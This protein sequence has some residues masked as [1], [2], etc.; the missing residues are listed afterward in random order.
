MSVDYSSAGAGRIS[1]PLTNIVL[2]FSQIAKLEDPLLAM[3]PAIAVPASRVQIMVE[4]DSDLDIQDLERPDSAPIQGGRVGKDER[5]F[6]LRRYS[7]QHEVDVRTIREARFGYDPGVKAAM[8]SKMHVFRSEMYKERVRRVSDL[9]PVGSGGAT[10]K[11]V[12]DATGDPW[13]NPAATSQGSKTWVEEGIRTLQD[14]TGEGREAFDV[15]LLGNAESAA[16][17]DPIFLERRARGVAGATNP[18][19]EDLRQYWGVRSV[20]KAYSVGR[21]QAGGVVQ[22]LLPTAVAIY[23]N[24]GA[25]GDAFAAAGIPDG[26]MRFGA[27]LRINDGEALEP[28]YD[29]KITSFNFPWQMESGTQVFSTA[30]GLA[31]TNIY[32]APV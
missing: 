13:N 14:E 20:R 17:N 10:Y 8:K 1:V 5:T 22:Q 4:D 7:K 30:C 15:M 9:T 6:N 29:P 21:L 16:M 19:L 31:I 12:L 24:G 26:N 18:S 32:E 11:N 27:T 25:L 23:Y 28:Y 3:F 2:R